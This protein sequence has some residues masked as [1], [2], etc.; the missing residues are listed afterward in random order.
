MNEKKLMD[1]HVLIRKK[2]N[3]LTEVLDITNQMGVAM[4]K[5]DERTL[6]SLLVMR[7]EPLSKLQEIQDEITAYLD[8]LTEPEEK[9]VLGV[10]SG[11][12]FESRQ[13]EAIANQALQ[14]K[15]LLEQLISLDGRLNQR[16]AGKESRK[17]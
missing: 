8:T 9:H 12:H 3:L 14:N 11:E 10:L 17:K 1:I 7:H 15:E 5:N 16:L 13:E 4:D 6:K 2:F